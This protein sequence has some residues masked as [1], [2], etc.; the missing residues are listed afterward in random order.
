MKKI[1]IASNNSHKIEEFRQILPPDYELKSPSD[2]LKEKLDVA[3]TGN[4]FR[5]NACLKAKAFHEASGL[6]T[7]ADDSGLEVDALQG[8]PGVFSS[9]F[10]GENATDKDNRVKLL[11]EISA[12]PDSKRTA[13]FVCV[14]CAIIDGKVEYFE[15]KCDGK[16]IFEEKGSG[17]FGYDPVFQPAGYEKTFAELDSSIKNSISHRAFASLKFVDYLNSL[18]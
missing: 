8:D 2:I 17:G 18:S 6:D 16:I 10:A 14:I 12:I 15:G 4:T 3:E 5:E 11:H 9:R 13:R 7:F 1:L